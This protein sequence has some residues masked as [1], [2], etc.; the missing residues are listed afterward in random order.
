MLNQI[1]SEVIKLRTTRSSLAMLGA[2]VVVVAL[3]VV[4]LVTDSDAAAL[5]RPLEQQAFLH[6]MLTIAPL[7]ALLLGIRSFTD[8]FRFGSIVPTLLANPRRARVLVAKLVAAAA[9]AIA[10]T[11]AA[12]AASLAIGVPLIAARGI[13]LDWSAAPAATLVARLLTAN[14]LWAILGV[15]YGLA[16]R[17]QVA[18]IGAALVWILAG[19]GILA[20]LLPHVARFFPGAA[21]FG[22]VGVN[23]DDVLSFAPAALLLTAYAGAASIVGALLMQRRD[24]V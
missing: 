7:F 12:T 8:E 23:P 19:E 9:A 5:S 21:G 13:G 15:G 1:R 10:L 14:V 4:A 16:M 18:A 17:H 6:V 22:V 3:G 11:F 20:G 24:V 2:L